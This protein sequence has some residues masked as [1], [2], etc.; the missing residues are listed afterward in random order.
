MLSS[1]PSL[2]G[3]RGLISTQ[4]PTCCGTLRKAHPLCAPDFDLNKKEGLPRML[5]AV[6]ARLVGPYSPSSLGEQSR[7]RTHP[8]W[9]S[10]GNGQGQKWQNKNKRTKKTS[11]KRGDIPDGFGFIEWVNILTDMQRIIRCTVQLQSWLPFL[12]GVQLHPQPRAF[13]QLAPDV[14]QVAAGLGW[15]L[16]QAP[17]REREVTGFACAGQC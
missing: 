16:R 12:H 1:C 15:W 6:S 10:V 5:S 17:G 4:P 2:Q 3:S 9:R 14:P 11:C 7:D 8:G 13:H